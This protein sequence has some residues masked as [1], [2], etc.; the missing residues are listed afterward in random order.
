MGRIRTPP[1]LSGGHY[2]T[3]SRS[4]RTRRA[5]A[6]PP[7]CGAAP[8]P[9]LLPPA[10]GAPPQP[11]AESG[12]AGTPAPKRD[13]AHSRSP[14]WSSRPGL[15]RAHSTRD[16]ALTMVSAARRPLQPRAAAAAALAVG[17]PQPERD[18][19]RGPPRAASTNSR[20]RCS[21]EPR[22]P[23]NCTLPSSHNSALPVPPP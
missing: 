17:P 11:P 12:T 3:L 19:A 13:T 10:S 15:L 4:L 1:I 6:G 21:F 2:V 22:R 23:A 7:L 9:L 8:A 5:T 20:S 14:R 16:P 18:N